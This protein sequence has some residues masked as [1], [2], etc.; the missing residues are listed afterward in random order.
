MHP[1]TY[2]K[3]SRF[4]ETGRI[5]ATE[6]LEGD[7]VMKRLSGLLVVALASSATLLAQLGSGVAAAESAPSSTMTCEK[8]SALDAD[9]QKQALD[10]IEA[11]NGSHASPTK[12]G[13]IASGSQKKASPDATL[14]KGA[15]ATA[16]SNNVGT[17][18]Q[19]NPEEL[20]G[21]ALKHSSTM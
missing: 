7:H 8:F 4:D 12:T 6:P 18:C 9:G 1:A 14:S 5:L 21:N 15:D 2:D 20:L 11:T 10:A 3:R 13:S 16:I 19:N 17:Y